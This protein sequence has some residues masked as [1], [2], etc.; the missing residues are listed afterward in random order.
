DIKTWPG[1]GNFT[2]GELPYLAPFFDADNNGV[3]DYEAGDYPYFLLEGDYQSNP[4]T[5]K[6]ECN[7]YLFGDKSIWWVFNDVGNIKTE[8]SS[9]PIGLEIRAQAFAFKT[10]NEINFMT[11][12]KYQIINRS[13][14]VLDSTYFGVWCDPDLG[15][16]SD[17]LVG[18]DVGLGLGFVYNG[19]P[20]DDGGGGYGTNPPAAGIDFFQGPL[21]DPNDGIDNNKDGVIDEPGE[22][23]IMSRFV[24]YVNV[25]NTPNGNPS[26]TDDYYEYLSGSWL[27]G[28]PI[29]YGGDG[30]GGGSGATGTPCSYMFPDNTDPNFAT[31]WTMVTA[32][33]QPDDMRWL[34]SAGTFTLRPGA[35]N[36]ITTGMIWQ[37][38]TS[39]GPL[40][41]VSLLKLADQKAQAIFD[42]CFKILDGPDAPNV[43]LREMHR[44]VILSLENVN[45]KK[46]ELYN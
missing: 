12:Y 41:S 24:Y 7:D 27:D 30:R 36:Y 34:Q 18:C 37:R 32:N 19:D 13:S 45:T 16:A 2:R 22:Q 9:D 6:V 1:N 31:P 35:V 38:T 23:I 3:Y 11:F 26:T 44:K 20:D 21:A 25:N 14:D 4:T 28:L 29:T 42:N 43:A 15:N 10:A 17:D 8:T 40:A 39:G 33:L 5:G 46:V